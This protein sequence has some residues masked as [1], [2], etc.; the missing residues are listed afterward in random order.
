[1]GL[2]GWQNKQHVPCTVVQFLWLLLI[3]CVRN[4]IFT[5]L[6]I[7]LSTQDGS[8]FFFQCY[9]N[10]GPIAICTK[11][12]QQNTA[13]VQIREAVPLNHASPGLAVVAD[14]RLSL[15][16][17]RVPSQGTIQHPFIMAMITTAK[18]IHNLNIYFDPE[19]IVYRT[20]L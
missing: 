1:M 19:K 2:H 14:V 7:P 5:L 9:V 4:V 16:V 12:P 6:W 10:D 17:E 15:P 11:V 20:A 13:W 18:E 8:L 3:C